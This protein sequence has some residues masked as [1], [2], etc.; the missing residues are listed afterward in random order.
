MHAAVGRLHSGH[1]APLFPDLHHGW[2]TLL[3]NNKLFFFPNN[4]PSPVSELFCSLSAL[5]R[6]I[7]TLRPIIFGAGIVNIRIKDC[8]IFDMS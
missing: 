5:T 7:L 6:H 1:L 4:S 2:L 3:V 8:A